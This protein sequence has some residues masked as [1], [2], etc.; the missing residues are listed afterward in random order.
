MRTKVRDDSFRK[1]FWM[2]HTLCRFHRFGDFVPNLI[3][4]LIGIPPTAG[5]GSLNLFVLRLH[6]MMLII[7]SLGLVLHRFSGIISCIKGGSWTSLYNVVPSFQGLSNCSDPQRWA[8]RRQSF[9]A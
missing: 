2:K 4:V 3:G 5:A 6:I 1:L 8:A 7:S 9:P